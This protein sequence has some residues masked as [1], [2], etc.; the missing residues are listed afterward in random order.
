MCPDSEEVG[1]G[2]GCG[3]VES[4]GTRIVVA[5]D[6]RAS[7]VARKETPTDPERASTGGMLAP[8][9]WVTAPSSSSVGVFIQ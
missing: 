7:H 5:M 6:I 2:V 4:A 9:W 3:V 8:G 1:G